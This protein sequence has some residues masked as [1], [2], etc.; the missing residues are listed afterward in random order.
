MKLSLAEIHALNSGK[1]SKELVEKA[2]KIDAAK[3]V[4]AEKPAAKTAEKTA[5][6]VKK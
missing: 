5:K 3:K 4:K 6:Q 1:A 2:K